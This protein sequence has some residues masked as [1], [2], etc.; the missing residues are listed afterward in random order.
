[1]LSSDNP[2]DFTYAAYT[3]VSGP[4]YTIVNDL[5]TWQKRFYMVLA[6]H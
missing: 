2:T 4:P 3:I 6:V 1:V 5:G